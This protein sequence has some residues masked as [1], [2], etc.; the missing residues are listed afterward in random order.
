[1]SLPVNLATFCNAP[2]SVVF[3]HTRGSCFS[4]DWIVNSGLETRNSKA[5]GIL[6]LPSN[7][8][9]VSGSMN[10]V[11]VAVGL[12]SDLVLGLDWLQ[13]VGNLDTGMVVYLSSGPLE[14]RNFRF[15]SS[16]STTPMFKHRA[17]I[18]DREPSSLP[19]SSP[20]PEDQYPLPVSPGGGPGEVLS[21]QSTPRTRGVATASTL[22]ASP[23]PRTRGLNDDDIHDSFVRLA[24][25]EKMSV[26]SARHQHMHVRG[27]SERTRKGADTLRAEFL[28][29]QCTEA[30]LVLKSEAMVAGFSAVSLSDTE[31]YYEQL[32]STP[33]CVTVSRA[34]L[35]PS[36]TSTSNCSSLLS[37]A[38]STS[39]LSSAVSQNKYCF[40]SLVVYTSLERGLGPGPLTENVWT[41]DFKTSLPPPRLRRRVSY[42]V[43][44]METDGLDADR[45]AG[46]GTGLRRESFRSAGDVV[47]LVN[48]TV[49]EGGRLVDCHRQEVTRVREGRRP[50]G[51]EG[52]GQMEAGVE[53]KCKW[54][55]ESKQARKR[56]HRPKRPRRPSRVRPGPKEWQSSPELV[57]RG[58]GRMW[59]RGSR[60]REESGP[61][62]RRSET[63]GSEGNSAQEK[64]SKNKQ[65]RIKTKSETKS[66]QDVQHMARISE[67]NPEDSTSRK[68]EYGKRP[69]SG[70]IPEGNGTGKVRT[71]DGECTGKRGPGMDE[72]NEDKARKC[73]TP[74]WL[75][76]GAARM[77]EAA[78]AAAE[79]PGIGRQ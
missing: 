5:S 16:S 60:V 42:P 75:E 62:L 25:H 44:V 54:F 49:H 15:L 22:A 73:T 30:C 57:N 39:L 46:S 21:P 33:E 13:S 14:L 71:R 7:N 70:R 32:G 51:I 48:T 53:Y 29:H 12:P 24:V 28:A 17:D 76:N 67:E 26:M 10:I 9:V 19:A 1:M 47:F 23:T 43:P 18:E 65:P 50:R 37:T 72:I 74:R 36:S 11:P 58:P 45:I 69:G 59:P 63:A 2:L 20:M 8:S 41:L 31:I 68:S 79:D 40:P 27:P 66:E 38:P 52:E 56:P 35:L 6:T 64:R 34:C 3:D 78:D 4:L 61:D 55:G 77:A